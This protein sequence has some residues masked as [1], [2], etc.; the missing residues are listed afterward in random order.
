MCF[1][2]KVLICWLHDRLLLLLLLI[3]LFVNVVGVGGNGG[4]VG[5]VMVVLFS[6]CAAALFIRVGLRAELCPFRRV[7]VFVCSSAASL[8]SCF[9]S[10]SCSTKEHYVNRKLLVVEE[11][12]SPM[13][14]PSRGGKPP[15]HQV[16]LP[17][18]FFDRTIILR[19]WL[20]GQVSPLHHL[21]LRG[22]LVVFCVLTFAHTA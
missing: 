10:C 3:A 20:E 9:C 16:M 18:S 15:C 7:A 12:H 14:R 4:G 17:R 6:W 5:L 21:F 8:S 13:L 19:W 2:V 22:F 1:H 11:R